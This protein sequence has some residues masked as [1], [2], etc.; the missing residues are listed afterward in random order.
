MTPSATFT[1]RL[2]EVLA[3]FLLWMRDIGFFEWYVYIPVMTALAVGLFLILVRTTERNG[4]FTD[5]PR[6]AL[7]LAAYFGLC[8]LATNGLAV[9]LK[10]LIVE[11]LDYPTRVWFEAYLGPLH[12]YIVAV[13]LS[14]LALIARN[15][16]AALDWGLGLFVQIGLLAGYSVGVFRLLNEPMTLAAP[17]MG[18]SGSHHVRRVRT[19]QRRPVPAIRRSDLRARTT[20]LS[21]SVAD[22]AGR[23]ATSRRVR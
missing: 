5:R 11:E 10:T 13:A 7:W 18:L 17:T 15:T 2:G 19:L 8:F 9:G 20:R 22:R 14:Y 6:R 21:A 3:P 4:T 1:N 12:F 16:T 23:P